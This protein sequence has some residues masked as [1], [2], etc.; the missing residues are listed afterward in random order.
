MTELNFYEAVQ[1]FKGNEERL[2]IFV[3]DPSSEGGY[4]DSNGGQVESLPSLAQRAQ[5]LEL[6][7]TDS[8]DL[9]NGASAVARAH[10]S[11]FRIDGDRTGGA[12][13]APA[14]ARV[15]NTNTNG[16][17]VPTGE[18]R[19]SS[20]ID[21]AGSWLFAAGAVLLPDAGVTVRTKAGAQIKC[22]GQSP[23]SSAALGSFVHEAGVQLDCIV[24]DKTGSTSGASRAIGHPNNSYDDTS[25]GSS[26]WCGG[27]SSFPNS[28]ASGCQLTVIGGGYDNHIEID[29]IAAAILSGAHHFIRGSHGTICGGAYQAVNGSYG[30]SGAGQY[31]VV[32]SS[33]S[34][35]VGGQQNEAGDPSAA[36]TLVK[37]SAF[38]GA[39]TQNKAHGLRSAVAAG[40]NNTASGDNSVVGA[41][42]NC[43]ALGN[44]SG[45]LG[46][47]A[48]V[49][50][51][52]YS[53]VLGGSSSTASGDYAVS[54]GTSQASGVYSFAMGDF[55]VAA[56]PRA[57]AQGGR[58]RAYLDGQ[59]A[60]ANGNFSTPGDKQISEFVMSRQTTGLA[61]LPLG[62]YGGDQPAVLPDKTTWAFRVLLVA[63]R[64]D[65]SGEQA[66]WEF[67]GLIKRDEGAATT[68]LVGTVAKTPIASDPAASAWDAAVTAD[69]TNGAL[70]ITA[71]PEAGKTIRWVARVELTEVR[72]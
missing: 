33:F 47:L 41:G 7:L 72:A 5:V 30:F 10:E 58:S 38:V 61:A 60:L 31:N 12:D 25:A 46:G 32:N 45:V 36:D 28:V 52:A 49:A 44:H 3:N 9:S 16:V 4:Q 69:S 21:I 57:V 66:A 27:T 40:L 1:R 48:C 2:N 14:F 20:D 51:G 71:T 59:R 53:G 63:R 34:V 35:V 55:N 8:E 39:G 42:A 67:V 6:K 43:E 37:R 18:Y 65:V 26:F 15:P 70:R 62:L 22:E 23:F 11:N 17:Y 13:T 64:A 50:S 19:I 29:S 54:A 68:S 56:A 24:L